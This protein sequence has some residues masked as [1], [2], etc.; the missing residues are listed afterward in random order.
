MFILHVVHVIRSIN[1]VA[2]NLNCFDTWPDYAFRFFSWFSRGKRGTDVWPYLAV[3]TALLGERR[4]ISI[5]PVLDATTV[6]TTV[7]S[8]KKLLSTIYL[9]VSDQSHLLYEHLTS[10]TAFQGIQQVFERKK[11][12]VC[13]S[14]DTRS[15]KF[16]KQLRSRF[17][18]T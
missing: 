7:A 1:D 13:R 11:I 6:A 14:L 15:L 18:A 10:Q 12:K 8:I 9:S 3:E 16:R 5:K 4:E 17:L 2:L